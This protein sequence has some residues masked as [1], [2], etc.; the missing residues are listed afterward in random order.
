VLYLRI[1]TS[2]INCG[3]WLFFN[4]FP[5]WQSN[6]II[7]VFSKPM[8]L[9]S[10][11]NNSAGINKSVSFG[12]W[13]TSRGGRIAFISV[14]KCL[15]LFCFSLTLMVSPVSADT[16]VPSGLVSPFLKCLSISIS[17][18]LPTIFFVASSQSA[19]HWGCFLLLLF[20]IVKKYW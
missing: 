10:G 19:L 16:V 13:L 15:K 17:I 1:K 8:I 18:S 12:L 2:Q 11:T 9:F 14:S 6:L 3:S 5:F 4:K 20:I 7:E